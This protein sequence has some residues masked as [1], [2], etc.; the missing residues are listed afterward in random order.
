MQRITVTPM[1]PSLLIQLIRLQNHRHAIA[2]LVEKINQ[3]K[4]IMNDYSCSQHL[5]IPIQILHLILL[6]SV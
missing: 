6:M 1:R 2:A 3:N 4:I 5:A